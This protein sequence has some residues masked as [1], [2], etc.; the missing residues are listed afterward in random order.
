MLKQTDYAFKTN[1]PLAYYIFN[2]RSISYTELTY[3]LTFNK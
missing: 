1:Q 2:S 3:P